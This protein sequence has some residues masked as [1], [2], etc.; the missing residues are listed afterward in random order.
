MKMMSDFLKAYGQSLKTPET[1]SKPHQGGGLPVVVSRQIGSGGSLFATELAK[2]LDFELCGKVI[3]DEIAARS[4]VPPDLVN[5]MDERP[6]HVLEL[7]GA[8]LLRGAALN[9]EEFERYLKMTIR[10]LL[11]LG[12]VVILGRG[13][14]FLA[15]PGQALRV[16]IIAPHD[17]RVQG[18]MERFGV[19]EKDA[20]SQIDSRD[21]ERRS[22][23]KRVYGQSEASPE[24]F[25]LTINMQ[26]FTVPESVD[27]ALDAYRVL[28]LHAV[29]AAKH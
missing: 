27:L 25:D 1:Q 4:K 23:F 18:L 14:V 24:H 9:Q 12:R 20:K 11:R 19:S 13:G 10:G 15:E 17:F 26:C 2:R 28:Q 7:F 22:F 29:H 5:T 6:A 21:T 8:S 3:L 16:N